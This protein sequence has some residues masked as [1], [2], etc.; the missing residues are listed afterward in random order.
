MKILCVDDDAGLLYLLQSE[1]ET[2][3]YEVTTCED[4]AEAISL[5]T[6]DQFD[7]V[8]LDQ[9][10]P[11]QSG[12]EVIKRAQT[13][14]N[15]PPIIMVTGAGNEAVAVEAIRLG[16][17]DYVVKD[18]NLFYLKILRTVIQQVIHERALTQ[19]Q[20]AA[21]RAAEAEK[22]R[23]RLLG[24]FIRDASHEFRIP[25][26]IIQSSGELLQRL[27]DD[28][29]PQKYVSQMLQQS[30]R[31]LSLVDHLIQL[32][33]LENIVEL[34]RVPVSLNTVIQNALTRMKILIAKKNLT[35]QQAFTAETVTVLA[36]ENEL[37]DALVELVENACLAS[38]ADGVIQVT[39]SVE[40]NAAVVNLIDHGVGMTEE[41]VEHIFERFY[42]VDEAH[43]TPG[44]G[45]GLPVV[46]R[47]LELHAATISVTSEPGEGTTVTVTL[48]LAA[49][50][51]AS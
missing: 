26:T 7:A 34:E 24:Q 5:L 4:G 23:S 11:N 42:R 18:T 43:T 15:S 51:V 10:M 13:I 38:T 21:E 25:L 19:R 14:E 41:Q 35:L 16:A 36:D 47:I 50:E 33:R 37:T 48:P 8:I 9:E 29:K 1:L 31:I 20:Q 27:V 2:H 46:A 22:E 12:M 40:N 28:P 6:T 44:F 17:S 30:D 32:S 3:S 39:L 49:H 45:L